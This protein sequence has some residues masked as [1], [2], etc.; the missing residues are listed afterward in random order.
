VSAQGGQDILEANPSGA[1]SGGVGAF[2]I[3]LLGLALM[4]A[5][6]GA[7][8]SLLFL[9]HDAENGTAASATTLSSP[10]G[11]IGAAPL[12]ILP[13]SGL[14]EASQYV[15]SLDPVLVT[16]AGPQRSWARLELAVIF[17][18]KPMSGD[19]VLLKA[20]TEDIMS[21][22]R[23]VPLTHIETASG[24]EYLR[25]DLTEI[26]RLRSEGRARSIV[27]RSLVVE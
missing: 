10:N 8:F 9:G 23:T 17:E 2:A 16:L 13:R 20:M 27:L 6:A 14:A 4:G 1:A 18:G 22:M 5:G 24:V 15:A 7:G 26:I 19:E 25:E 3:I 21:F 12:S 11:E